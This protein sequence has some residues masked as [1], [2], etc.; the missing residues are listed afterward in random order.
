MLQCSSSCRLLCHRAGC[1][2]TKQEMMLEQCTCPPHSLASFFP[3]YHGHPKKSHERPLPPMDGKRTICA[4]PLL[5]DSDGQMVGFSAAFQHIC[6]AIID[7]RKGGGS[8]EGTCKSGL[9]D[10]PVISHPSF[11]KGSNIRA[12]ASTPFTF[13]RRSGG[14]SSG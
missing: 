7:R 4:P 5:S 13:D 10:S 8:E 14:D 12:D 6:Q 1:D 9:F 3:S 11:S 2:S